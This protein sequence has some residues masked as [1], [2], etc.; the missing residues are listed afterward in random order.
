MSPGIGELVQAGAWPAVTLLAMLLFLKPLSRLIDRVTHVSVRRKDGVEYLIRAAERADSPASVGGPVAPLARG[1]AHREPGEQPAP[2]VEAAR[3]LPRDWL[4]LAGAV[5][6]LFLAAALSGWLRF[7]FWVPVFAAA[8]GGAYLLLA[9]Y[10]F[11]PRPALAA[12]EPRGARGSWTVLAQVRV[13]LLVT[14]VAAVGGKYLGDDLWLR[15]GH[16]ES[17]RNLSLTHPSGKNDPEGDR[18]ASELQQDLL[19]SLKGGGMPRP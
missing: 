4:I 6:V 14:G 2:D 19:D 15:R 8:S 17:S 18:K 9:R 12:A 11:L 13:L 1:P 3:N 7:Y 16:E 10:R 5:S